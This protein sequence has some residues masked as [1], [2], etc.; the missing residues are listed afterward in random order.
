MSTISQTFKIPGDASGSTNGAFITSVDLYFSTK[1]D[2]VLPITLE[3]RNTVNGVP[4]PKILPF[5]RVVKDVGDV[6]T[7][8]TAETATT[9]TLPSPVYVETETLYCVAVSSNSPQYNLWIARMGETDIGEV[10]TISEQPH[11][12]TLFKSSGSSWAIS[13]M[14]DMKFSIKC[15]SFD[16]TAGGVCTLTNSDIPVRTLGTNPI[17]ITD[18]STTLKINHPDHH[19]YDTSNNVTIAGV[20]SG[21]VTTLNGAITAAATTLTLTSGTNFDDTTG[22]YAQLAAGTWYIKIDDEIM[23]YS[24]I[25]T[26]AVS[27]LTR[28]VDSTTAAAHVDGATVELYQVYKVPLTEIN[29]THT[30]IANPEIDSYTITCSTTPDVGTSDTAAVGGTVATATENALMDTFSTIIGSMEL[31]NTGIAPKALIVRGTSASGSQTSYANSRDNPTTVPTISFPMNDNYKFDVPCMITS[32]INETNELSSRKSLELQLT[33]S[34]DSV[35]IS[36]V[37]DTGRMSMIAVANRLNNIDSSSDVYPTTDYV[38]STYPE[39]DQNAAVYLTKQVT[40]D[41]SATGLK[42]LFAAHRSSTSDIKVMYKILRSDASDD[43]DDLGYTYFNSDGSPDS[44]VNPSASL[45]DFQ[46]Y[47]YT[48]G[49]TDDGIGAPLEEFISFQIKIIMQGTNS[50]EPPRIKTFRVLALGT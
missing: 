32:A 44:A 43:F 45:N 20:K 8:S 15:A 40:L 33:M 16:D 7:S 10:R 35:R 14:E 24:T 1:D 9:F 25:S 42:V 34:T 4:G 11:T 19:M 3:L 18:A 49:V 2:G 6:N 22:T 12:G 48:A 41:T 29:K 5:S 46:E 23:T 36:P 39:G 37:I 31:P 27:S 30:A 38:P 21:A 17:S 28:G 13:P 50:A 26:N 47:Q